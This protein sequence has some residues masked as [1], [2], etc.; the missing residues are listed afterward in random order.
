M[1]DFALSGSQNCRQIVCQTL[2]Q[3]PITSKEPQFTKLTILFIKHGLT[4]M[5][6][7]EWLFYHFVINLSRVY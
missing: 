1:A 6:L 5:R 4:Q 3:N 2:L 7:T